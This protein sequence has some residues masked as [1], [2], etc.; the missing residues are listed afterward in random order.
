MSTKVA[1]KYLDRDGVCKNLI[2]GE[3][4]DVVNDGAFE[5]TNPAD[6]RVVLA[7]FPRAGLDTAKAA[8]DAAYDAQKKWGDVT[9]PERAKVLFKAAEIL[10]AEREDFATLLTTEEGKTLAES[11]GEI[12]RALSVLRFFS[13]SGYRLYG[14]TIPSEDPKV[15]IYTRKEPL[16]V[17][18][19]VT[20]W[21]FPFL[22]PAW[23]IAPALVSGNAVVLKPASYTPYIAMR[24]VEL[25]ERAGLSKGVLNFITGSGEVLGDELVRNPK[26]AAVSFTGS[27]PV[28]QSIQ[29]LAAGRK[30][31][32]M[33][34]VQLEMGGKNPTVVMD[35]A[36]L[37]NATDVVA[38]GA[39]GVT[40]QSC[41]ATERVIV[42]TS[43]YDAFLKRL[44]EK[45]SRIKVG[46][47]LEG[48]EMGPL[49]SMGEKKKVLGFFE[50]GVGEGARVAFGGAAPADEAHANGAFVQPTIFTDVGPD[51]AI[52]EE[53]V[54]G[55]V[56]AMFRFS[57][58]DEAIEIANGV[59]YGLLSGLCTNNIATIQEFVKK[60][61]AGVVRVNRPTTGI[62]P[63]APFGGVKKSGTNTYREN[64]DSAVDFY[65]QLKTVYI[66]T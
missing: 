17:V 57:K 49:V 47:G 21:N 42:H 43:V 25:F 27:N 56:V 20:P 16:G 29:S 24:F 14:L 7:K 18:S 23:K 30:S 58:L 63:Q 6:T 28:G 11:R 10:D 8:I 26:V 5:D 2:A 37:E 40:G 15:Q 38:R 50:R 44:V 32:S 35:D 13:G 22:I 66:G 33:M 34:R 12:A 51:M 52:A 39:F 65:T 53:E 36:D 19:I 1:E 54:F 55:P 60:I 4:V 59:E 46:N 45:A 31:S 62:E 64:G 41:S 61:K 3:W 48:A 9:P